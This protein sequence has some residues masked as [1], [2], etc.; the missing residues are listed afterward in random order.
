MTWA[1]LP[2]TITRD[3]V[4]LRGWR[5]D[6]KAALTEARDVSATELAKWWPG[7]SKELDDVAAFIE[8]SVEVFNGGELSRF[9]LDVDGELTGYLSVTR[10]HNDAGEAEVAYWVRTDRSGRGIA[11]A[12][13][14][15]VAVTVF[16]HWP[17]L[18]RVVLRCEG[19]NT[20][21]MKVAE[22]SG[23]A[24]SADTGASRPPTEADV[25][26]LWALERER[27]RPPAP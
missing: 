26:V 11:T 13:V 17:D 24:R 22:R 15:T 25:E 23:F 6:D 9:A 14:Q 12:A 19:G 20:G 1:P 7:M 5:L 3:L 4:T 16:D 2:Q 21:S 27:G 8:Y 10:L 18:P